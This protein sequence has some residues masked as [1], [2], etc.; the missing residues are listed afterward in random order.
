MSI[1][2]QDD[3]PVSVWI[4]GLRS[5]DEQATRSVYNYFIDH[6]RKTV[7]RRIS[8]STRPL[9]DED[10][11]AQSAFRSLYRGLAAG[12]Y[13]DVQNRLSLWRLLLMIAARKVMYRHRHDAQE[14]RDRKQE[15]PLSL[16]FQ[17]SDS[18]PGFEPT[19]RIP[20]PE[21]TAEFEELCIELFQKLT[22]STLVE[23]AELKL[24]G[25]ETDEIATKLTYSPRTIRRKLER[26]RRLW[27]E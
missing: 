16:V 14:M 3:N 7:R 8:E 19:A 9:Y 5:G 2:F 21:Y 13:P 27:S 1:T 26:I 11:V 17:E 4:E 23:I 20:T 15:I 6:L 12:R 22:D 24:A 18:S 10:D 25:Y